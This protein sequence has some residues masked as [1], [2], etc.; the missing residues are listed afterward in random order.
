MRSATAPLSRARVKGSSFGA[1]A[2]GGASSRLT[3][4]ETKVAAWV[5]P[6]ARK[7]VHP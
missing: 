3:Y 2:G 5:L 6:R 4:W 7:G 1:R